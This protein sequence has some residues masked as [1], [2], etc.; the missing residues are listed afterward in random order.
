MNSNAFHNVA[1][2]ASL[3]LAGT[4]AVLLAS[5]C[6]EIATG[7]F[8]CAGSWINP[9]FTAAAIAVLQVIKLAVNVVR[10][11]VGGLIK[12]QPPVVR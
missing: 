11:G 2:I 3:V 5:G 12:P 6:T 7:T 1:N 9:A 4:T 10:D 8:D